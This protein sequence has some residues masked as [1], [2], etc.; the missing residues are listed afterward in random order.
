MASNNTND[1]TYPNHEWVPP[2]LTAAGRKFASTR[3]LLHKKTQRRILIAAP[4][5][6]EYMKDAPADQVASVNAFDGRG[7]GEDGT[8]RSD[9]NTALSEQPHTNPPATVATKTKKALMAQ[10]RGEIQIQTGA[11]MQQQ[12]RIHCRE[13]NSPTVFWRTKG[14]SIQN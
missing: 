2:L 11:G 10:Q 4:I 8:H 13:A 5:R 3:R 12:S 9:T 1:L 6:R 14:V 7:E